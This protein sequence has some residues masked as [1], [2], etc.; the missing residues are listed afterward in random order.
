MAMR[1]RYVGEI[2]GMMV[3]ATK[4]GGREEDLVT[5]LIDDLKSSAKQRDEKGHQEAMWR[6]TSMFIASISKYKSRGTELVSLCF[7]YFQRFIAICCAHS[8][9]H[10]SN[11]STK[12][13]WNA[14]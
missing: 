2:R 13:L 5:C 1:T 10:W 3:A 6:A 8:A 9:A 4:T 11:F 7:C 12:V 14:Q